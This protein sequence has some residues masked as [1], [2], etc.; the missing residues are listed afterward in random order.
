MFSADELERAIDMQMG[1]PYLPDLDTLQAKLNEAKE[2]YKAKGDLIADMP[3][4]L[5]RIVEKERQNYFIYGVYWY[6]IKAILAKHF[7]SEYQLQPLSP[8]DQKMLN[9]Y[10]VK[11]RNG[12]PSDILTVLAAED[13]KLYYYSHY[14]MGNR[15]FD[16]NGETYHLQDLQWEGKEPLDQPTEKHTVLDS[17]ADLL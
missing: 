4:N 13:F 9:D 15:E 1:K 10:T 14:F 12:K 2:N 7:P 8:I 16:L 17:L 3:K 5:K 6:P 11:D